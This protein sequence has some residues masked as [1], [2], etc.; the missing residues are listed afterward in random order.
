M[1]EQIGGELENDRLKEFFRRQHDD[2]KQSW[3]DAAEHAKRVQGF[4]DHRSG[5]IPWLRTTGIADHIKGLTKD[6]LR[7]A[8][9][10]PH[11]RE[12][13][14]LSVTLTMRFSEKPMAC[15]LTGRTAC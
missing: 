1:D 4:N 12:E 5:P 11:E 10:L 6:E 8:I 15:A 7:A 13:G 9:A 2:I 14:E 3:Q